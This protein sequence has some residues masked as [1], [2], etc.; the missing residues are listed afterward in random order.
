[1]SKLKS[2]IWKGGVP[3]FQASLIVRAKEISKNPPEDNLSKSNLRNKIIEAKDCVK[4]Y[5]NLIISGVERPVVIPKIG[6]N[7]SMLISITAHSIRGLFTE[8]PSTQLITN[9][10][11][12]NVLV[13]QEI[14]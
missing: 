3:I 12:K 10:E 7:K 9:I 6:I 8:R 14:I 11:V 4:K 2:H 1:M 13:N 5:L